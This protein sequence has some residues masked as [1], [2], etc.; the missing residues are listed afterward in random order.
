M[1]D[2]S[3]S[4]S[5]GLVTPAIV[6][7]S[8]EELK[9]SEVLIEM[10]FAAEDHRIYD[11]PVKA[12]ITVP[13]EL[14]NAIRVLPPLIRDEANRSYRAY[15]AL[16]EHLKDCCAILEKEFSELRDSRPALSLMNTS[17]LN[18]LPNRC[19][20]HFARSRGMFHARKRRIAMRI[21]RYREKIQYLEK[22]II[23][24]HVGIPPAPLPCSLCI[25]SGIGRLVAEIDRPLCSTPNCQY[26]L[27]LQCYYD[28][29]KTSAPGTTPKCPGCRAPFQMRGFQF[30]RHH[31]IFDPFSVISDDNDESEM[32]EDN[33]VEG[34]EQEED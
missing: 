29:K 22:H 34:G 2:T 14:E 15:V 20:A 30:V 32:E 8:E 12:E 9:D 33:P 4:T 23:T 27:C 7:V 3:F 21:A 1:S 13:I 10:E 6:D 28:V 5:T 24:G 17:Y 11:L 18:R 26:V 16:Y 31:D 19:K 25:V